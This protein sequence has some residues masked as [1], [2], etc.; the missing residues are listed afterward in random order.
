MLQGARRGRP[1]RRGRPGIRDKAD[2]K[3]SSH[4]IEIPDIVDSPSDASSSTSPRKPLVTRGTRRRGRPFARRG[5]GRGGVVPTSED[6]I[7][8]LDEDTEEDSTKEDLDTSANR[9]ND[10][11]ESVKVD[12]E[13]S[14][15]MPVRT[16]RKGRTNVKSVEIVEDTDTTEP[17]DSEEKVKSLIIELTKVKKPTRRKS[18]EDNKED[19]D[20]DTKDNLTESTS[21]D[22]VPL[23][24]F[25]TKVR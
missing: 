10:D 7:L 13:V 12:D 18:T 1:P 16:S 17:E 22:D 8:L 21:D 5:R 14:V 2:A 15:R 20:E 6:K 25:I 24:Q 4:I 3:E 11:A 19:T 23:K 9:D